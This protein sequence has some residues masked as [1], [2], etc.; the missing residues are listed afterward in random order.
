MVA[1]AVQLAWPGP[2][3]SGRAARPPAPPTPVV[4]SAVAP[5]YPQILSRPLF[6]PSRGAAGAGLA[7]QA[8]ST[9]LSDYTLAGVTHVGGRGEAVMRGPGG[10]VVSLRPG[11]TLLGWQVA[12][13]ER[14]GIVLQQGDIRRVIAVSSSAAPKTGAQ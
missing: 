14:G 12:A 5:D 4:A 10:E 11:D 13:V 9:V 6:T 3:P 8:A 7:S 2:K 1:M